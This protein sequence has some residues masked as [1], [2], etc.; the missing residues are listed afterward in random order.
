L[1]GVYLPFAHPTL[2]VAVLLVRVGKALYRD[3]ERFIP[4][5]TQAISVRKFSAVD[6]SPPM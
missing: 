5:K 1:L 4:V 2:M 3:N 6:A